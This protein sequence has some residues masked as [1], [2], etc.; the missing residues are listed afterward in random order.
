VKSLF[1]VHFNHDLSLFIGKIGGRCRDY[2]GAFIIY[3]SIC[4]FIIYKRVYKFVFLF[5]T[6]YFELEHFVDNILMNCN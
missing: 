4:I 1:V 6:F 3:I 5:F 2:Y